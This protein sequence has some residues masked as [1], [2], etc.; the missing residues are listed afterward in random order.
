VTDA[1]AEVLSHLCGQGHCFVADGRALP[2]CQRCL[3]LY[4]AAAVTA[5]WVA[6][7]GLWRRGLPSRSVFLV[8]VVMLLAAMTGGLH[9]I[10]STPARRAACGL[11]TGHVV[12]LWLVGAAGLLWRRRRGD[13]QL[14]WRARDKVPGLA[15]PVLLALLAALLPHA[16]R[17]GWHLWTAA[18]AAGA[19]VLAAAAAAAAVSVSAYLLRPRRPATG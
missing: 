5:V 10:A 12:L 7:S 4:L 6:A 11:W 17:A 1:I 8:H 13:R 19:V 18:V 16:T 14:P 15:A 9:L 3:G 2:V